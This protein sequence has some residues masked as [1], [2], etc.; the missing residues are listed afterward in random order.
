MTVSRSLFPILSET[1]VSDSDPT[2]QIE[3][4]GFRPSDNI[5]AKIRTEEN[6]EKIFRL[7]VFLT[8][9]GKLLFTVPAGP[10][11]NTNLDELE[12][13][14]EI[15]GAVIEKLGIRS[16]IGIIS[17]GRAGDIGRNPVVDQ[18]ILDAEA[19][20]K[21]LNGKGILAKHYTILIEDAVKTANFLI[22][23]DSLSGEMILKTVAGVGDG[24]EIGNILLLKR[25][26]EKKAGGGKIYIE[27]LTKKADP[28][29]LIILKDAL[30][31]A[32]SRRKGEQK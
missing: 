14:A 26:D 19:L 11:M 22:I 10:D 9:S 8:H 13:C 18:T 4:L 28:N 1:D 29:D 2:L 23:P 30:T 32:F 21:K 25:A 31:A 17:G 27:Q 5:Y 7:S 16:D 6:A 15:G 12:F 3:N 20:E 24:A